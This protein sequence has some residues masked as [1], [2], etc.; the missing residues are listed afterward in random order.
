MVF[1]GDVLKGIVAAVVGKNLGGE[2]GAYLAG[3]FVVIGHNWPALLNF[4]GGKGV[5]TTV[6]VMLIVNAYVTL[7]C[8]GIGAAFIVFSR[9][10][11]LGSIIG[12]G[13]SPIVVI[14]FVRPFSVKLFLFC[15]FIAS[16]SIFRHRDNI[17]RLLNG[18]ENKL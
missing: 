13:L 10:V 12:M 14:L 4:K 3:A 5:A 15:L 18:N 1:V 7:I 9:M 17:K 16:M 6:G 8:L 11:S 2:V